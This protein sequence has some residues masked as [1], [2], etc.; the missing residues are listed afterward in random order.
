MQVNRIYNEDCFVG[1]QNMEDDSVAHV[2]TSPPYNRKRNDKYNN[3]NDKVDDYL[4]FMRKS[5]DEAMR[6][7]EGYVFFNIQKNYYN[8]TDVFNLIGEYSEY[9]VDIIIWN[10]INPMPANGHNITNAYEYILVFSK[11][12]TSL[13][14]N[15]TYTKNTV[16]TTVYS[17]NPY[18]KIHR[19]VMHPEVCYW[20]ID[21]FTQE[22]DLILDIFS[23]VG[24][25]AYCSLER[26]RR[27]IGFELDKHY[28]DIANERIQKATHDKEVRERNTTDMEGVFE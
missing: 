5:I 21:K 28:C 10:K 24:T 27:Y 6:V 3:Y 12:E 13:K 18:K 8:K 17:N 22:D 15:T 23:G 4:D 26:N 14:S 9:L 2:I 7:S 25:T 1:L 11:N 19:A 20:L 16:T